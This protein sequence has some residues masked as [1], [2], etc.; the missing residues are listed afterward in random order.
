MNTKLQEIIRL[1]TELAG[2][3]EDTLIS[4]EGVYFPSWLKVIGDNLKTTFPSGWTGEEGHSVK[5]DFPWAGLIWDGVKSW[6][7][8]TEEQKASIDGNFHTG[9]NWT[10]FSQ[11]RPPFRFVPNADH[12]AVRQT[13]ERALP[14]GHVIPTFEWEKLG[15]LENVWTVQPGSYD[16]E[17]A[18]RGA[19][20]AWVLQSYGI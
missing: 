8:I 1:A 16:T 19:V 15:P 14:G 4:P 12:I 13:G 5:V 6:P 20:E 3:S 17:A 2:E 10:L 7:G 9:P 18:L 11:A